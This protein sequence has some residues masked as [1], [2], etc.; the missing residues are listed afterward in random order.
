[1]IKNQNHLEDI[2]E[3]ISKSENNMAKNFFMNK[4]N[5]SKDI[6]VNGNVKSIYEKDEDKK[7]K[8][9]TLTEKDDILP[10]LSKNY[11]YVKNRTF[12]IKKMMNIEKEEEN[13]S[14]QIEK[15]LKDIDIDFSNE[16]EIEATDD[17]NFS[18]HNIEES[19]TKKFEELFCNLFYKKKILKLIMIRNFLMQK[20]FLKKDSQKLLLD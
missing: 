16:D 7:D 3:L 17:I 6:D 18:L 11:K 20:R 9:F 12:N 13:L 4:F 14:L 2:N 5:L 1:M 8:H 10:I 19:Y 15:E